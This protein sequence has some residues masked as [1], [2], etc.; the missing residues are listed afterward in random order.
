MRPI[1]LVMTAFGPYKDR[2]V[3]DFTE[4]K[5]HRLFVISG[6]TG[7]GKTTIFDAICFA[8]YG[9]ASGEDRNDPKHLRSDFADD[10]VY[11]SVELI[12]ELRDRLYRIK[13]QQPHIKEGNKTPTGDRYEFYEIVGEHEIPCV[14]R[15]IVSEIN[16]KVEELIGLTREQFIQIVML[17]QGEFQKFLTS[18]TENKEE[19]LRRI[20]KTE[21]YTFITQKLKEKKQLAEEDYKQEKQIRDRYIAD[22]QAAVPERD[23]VL[24]ERLKEEN[25]NPYQIIEGLEEEALFYRQQIDGLTRKEKEAEAAYNKKLEEFHKA[26]SLNQKFNELEQKEKQLEELKEKEQAIKE[27][28]QQLQLAKKAGKVE[29][30]EVQVNH[31]RQETKEKEM[32]LRSAEN[33]YNECLQSLKK[34]EKTYEREKAKEPEREKLKKQL[35]KYKEWL[36]DVKKVNEKKTQLAAMK[37]GLGKQKVEAGRLETELKEKKELKNTLNER[38]KAAEAKV[39]TLPEQMERLM[40]LREQYKAVFKYIK[41]KN[42]V[43]QMQSK[44]KT[45]EAEYIRARKEYEKTESLWLDGQA[46]RLAAHLHD[47]EPCPVCG[48][49]EHPAKATGKMNA[50]SREELER[51]KKAFQDLDLAYSRLKAIWQDKKEELEQ[52][53]AVISRYQLSLE[54]IDQELQNIEEEGKRLNRETKQLQKEKKQLTGLKNDDEKLEKAL[55]KLEHDWETKR[56]AYQ[57]LLTKYKAEKAVY[58]HELSR[59]PETYRTLSRLEEE[60]STAEQQI[61]ELEDAWNT[62]QKQLEEAKQKT[63]SAQANVESLRKQREESEKNRIK[64]EQEFIAA[65][66]GA[67]FPDEESYRA[68]KLPEEQKELLET[69]IH[70][71]YQN[72]RALEIQVAEYRQDLAGQT[73]A[74]LEKLKEEAGQLKE[75][76]ERIHEQLLKSKQYLE[77]INRYKENIIQSNEKLQKY[78]H[79]LNIVTELYDMIRGQNEKRLSF[80][81]YLQIEFL[82]KILISANERLQKLSNGQYLLK[83]SER[84]EARGK[85]SGLG[86][87]VYDAITGQTRD[88]K[89]LSGGE[90]FNASLSLALGMTDVIQSYQGGVSIE[91]MFIDEGFGSLDDEALT[92][93]VD[94]LI[95]LQK[96]GR[97]VG[98]ISHVQELKNTIP[99][100]LEVIK[101]KEGYSRAK[102]TIK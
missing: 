30:Y 4:L 43:G 13:R 66:N 22:I 31:F 1:K 61:K 83:R 37:I 40:E 100:I 29:S 35:D 42:E 7:A 21:R 74:D 68:A 6:K 82:E 18:K 8:L 89:T 19:I 47:G 58:E 33:T 3:I 86:L 5:D 28:E 94:T 16:K 32:Q 20:F 27:K 99:A 39:S 84:Q 80:E 76:Y 78:E 38:I 41:L 72:M 97:M 48:S 11:T 52:E 23:S 92:K 53:A 10:D 25:Y 63:T 95:D 62:A 59:I 2:E 71:Y 50:P 75:A 51:V 55:A 67:G 81:R 65:V 36:P 46:S 101:T 26:N 57:E 14:E 64:A 24:F 49:K 9:S 12:F 60:I 93:A 54:Q 90:K 102:F 88:V 77:A 96:S 56:N 87:D 15:Q 91:T 79:R 70:T 85:Q 17:P 44:L 45:M 98:V 73:K 34:A 69:Q